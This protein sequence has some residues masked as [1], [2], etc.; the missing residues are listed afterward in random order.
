[1]VLWI[2]LALLFMHVPPKYFWPS[3]FIALTMPVALVLNIL[4]LFVW[5]F[6]RSYKAFLPVF[7]LVFF[8]G[9][10][11][12]GLALN[13]SA[14]P[15]DLAS[16]ANKLSVLSYNVRIFNTYAHLQDKNQ[17]SSKELIKWV[18]R[19]PADV[20]CLQEFY[21]EDKSK[22]YNTTSKI[23]WQREKYFFLSRTFVNR[24]GAEFGLA[25]VSKYPIV[26]KGTISFG[27]LTQNHGMY[28]DI[29]VKEDTVR[30]YNFHF[31]SMSIEEK[32]IKDTYKDQD[33]FKTEGRNVL[34]RFKKGVVKRSDQV[35]VLLEH[36]Q[37]SPHPVIFCGDVN[38][39][40]YSYT[41][42]QL[43]KHYTNAFVKKGFGIGATYNGILP[44]VRID[45][46]FC[47]PELE[48]LDFTL[49]DT[50]TYSDHFPL[51]AVYG[52][53]KKQLIKK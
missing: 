45:N 44:F 48:V 51:T 35:N 17:T 26:E 37:H 41:Y 14:D 50:I 39:V 18:A 19:N 20:Y 31:Q 1:M 38:D 22:V 29:K 9:Y 28:A 15:E 49:H 5:L 24:I 6:R 27:K 40:P 33:G 13:M 23:A 7:V 21:N 16:A 34:R 43:N 47:S 52:L 32:Q 10:Y 42:E 12:R 36:L 30:V 2:I 4:F 53:N 11:Q 25:I 46:Q 3:A 8:W